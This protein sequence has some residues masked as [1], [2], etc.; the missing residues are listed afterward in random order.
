VEN[1]YAYQ[2]REPINTG[3][4]DYETPPVDAAID[5]ASRALIAKMQVTM[6]D[7]KH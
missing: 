6:P 2:L 3:Q 1:H 5:E 7:V 4:S